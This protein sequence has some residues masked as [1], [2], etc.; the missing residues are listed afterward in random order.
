[1][2]NNPNIFLYLCMINVN[3]TI[4]FKI[5]SYHNFFLV[6][7]PKLID[8]DTLYFENARLSCF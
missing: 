1:M 5:Y 8:K 4:L 3:C 6:V 2:P 7:K